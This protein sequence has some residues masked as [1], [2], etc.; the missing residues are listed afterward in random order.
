MPLGACKGMTIP[1]KQ[2]RRSPGQDAKKPLDPQRPENNGPRWRL[3]PR[4][5][6]PQASVMAS[7]V[8]DDVGHESTCFMRRGEDTR[9]HGR[10]LRIQ[11]VLM[12][13]R[14]QAVPAW[15]I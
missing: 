5:F 6:A 2:K 9:L 13:G 12:R 10:F 3:G 15:T 11:A 1:T 7:G 8:R 14:V 4:A